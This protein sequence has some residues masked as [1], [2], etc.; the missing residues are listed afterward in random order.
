MKVA[1]AVASVLMLSSCFLA[2]PTYRDVP[3]DRM[4]EIAIMLEADNEEL[5]TVHRDRLK[6]ELSED[7][8]ATVDKVFDTENG[9]V[10]EIAPATTEAVTEVID[11]GL[12][13]PTQAGWI[14][15]AIAGGLV[16]VAGL[17]G[18]RGRRKRGR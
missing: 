4:A 6:A 12:E 10:A 7:F 1:L 11:R 9:V 3:P 13:D 16:L 18:Y 8:G 2:E 5:W 15:A 17:F 14:R